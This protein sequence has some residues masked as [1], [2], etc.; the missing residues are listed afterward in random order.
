VEARKISDFGREVDFLVVGDSLLVGWLSLLFAGV[1]LLFAW[2]SLLFA[3]VS[4][5]VPIADTLIVAKLL[6]EGDLLLVG[7]LNFVASMVV[8]KNLLGI[9]R[10][11]P[12]LAESP[13]VVHVYSLIAEHL[14]SLVAVCADSVIAGGAYSER[15]VK[16]LL[17]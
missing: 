2:V 8:D 16:I 1:I 10:V 17:V 5:L 7:C 11:N 4:L 13:L 12:L 15:W 6:M 3:W 14:K 9:R